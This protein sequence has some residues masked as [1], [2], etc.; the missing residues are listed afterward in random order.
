[1]MTMMKK[2]DDDDDEIHCFSK[3]R[4]PTTNMI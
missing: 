1:M 4:T 3:N 2:I